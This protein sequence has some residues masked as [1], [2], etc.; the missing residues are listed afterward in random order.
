MILIIRL[1]RQLVANFFVAALIPIVITATLLLAWAV[2]L[3]TI[4]QT[5]P[6]VVIIAPQLVTVALAQW[7]QVK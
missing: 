7:L 5:V 6:P 2:I 1:F 3:H 4:W